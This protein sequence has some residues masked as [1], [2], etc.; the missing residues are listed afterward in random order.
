VDGTGG[1]FREKTAAVS[2]ADPDF[3][4]MRL[5]FLG[6]GGLI[7]I[8]PDEFVKAPDRSPRESGNSLAPVD[9]SRPLGIPLPDEVIIGDSDAFWLES[10]VDM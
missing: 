8:L 7:F 6:A 1:G 3:I 9:K 4:P 5:L 10:E 2:A